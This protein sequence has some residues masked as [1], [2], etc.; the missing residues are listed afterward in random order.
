MSKPRRPR[1]PIDGVLL[2]DKPQGLTSNQALM[3]V[4]HLYQADKAGHTGSLDPLATGLL[5]VCLGEASKFTQYLLDADKTYRTRIRLGQRTATGDAEGEVLEE[6]PVPA[7]DAAA[8][9]AVLERFR[10]DIQQ[11]PSMYS[12]LKKDGRP[13]YELARKGIEV[14]RPARP[15]TIH[16]LELLAVDGN[17]WELEVHVS[18]GTYIRSLAE[19][20][21]VML[22]CGAHVVVLRRIALGPFTKPVMVTLE[23][24]EQ[25]LLS[26][27]GQSGGHEALDALLLPTWVGLADWPRV[28]LSENTAYYL[29]QG[30]PVQVSGAPREGSVLVFESG[31]RFLG[32]GEIDDDGRVAPKRLI[33]SLV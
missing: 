27:E 24:L 1:R 33:R 25:A 23:Q 11:V 9:E 7:L 6:K 22:G 12:A 31:G 15:V 4:R 32:I 18:K 16:R 30:Q 5:P 28:E 10:G 17:D 29:L 13:L 19:D 8:I 14:E 3:R 2:L 20:I 26:G 21:G